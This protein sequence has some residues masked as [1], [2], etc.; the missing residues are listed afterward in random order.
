MQCTKK[1][2]GMNLVVSLQETTGDVFFSGSFQLPTHRTSKYSEWPSKS[3][4]PK[5]NQ[6]TMKHK[7]N[8]N[9][10]IPPTHK[11]TRNQYTNETY[12]NTNKTKTTTIISGGFKK[13]PKGKTP[14]LAG[15]TPEKNRPDTPILALGFLARVKHRFSLSRP[16]PRPGPLPPPAA[17]PRARRQSGLGRPSC[18]RSKT[19]VVRNAQKVH[20]LEVDMIGAIFIYKRY[21]FICVDPQQSWI[22]DLGSD[23]LPQTVPCYLMRMLFG[24]KRGLSTTVE[25]TWTLG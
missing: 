9:Q 1:H 16:R 14:I 8:K 13:T 17:A 19:R 5:R 15:P 2:Q 21:I 10:G 23:S 20:V 12:G 7:K 4:F 3:R 25:G 6:H 22:L 18:P 11:K 24:V